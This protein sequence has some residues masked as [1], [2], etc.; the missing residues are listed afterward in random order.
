MRIAPLLARDA[1]E[2]LVCQVTEQ[3]LGS[4]TS[5]VGDSVRRGRSKLQIGE[6]LPPS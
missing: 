5:S 1:E 6:S 3:D 2:R 4:D